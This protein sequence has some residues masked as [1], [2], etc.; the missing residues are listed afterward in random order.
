MAKL[1]MP[2]LLPA[3]R[4]AAAACR[5]SAMLSCCH[6][7]GGDS[8]GRTLQA[9]I[10]SP[11]GEEGGGIAIHRQ[12][13]GEHGTATCLFIKACNAA[14]RPGYACMCSPA[15]REQNEVLGQPYIYCAIVRP[16]MC[17]EECTE[18]AHLL[19]G[20]CCICVNGGRRPRWMSIEVPSTSESLASQAN[21]IATLEGDAYMLQLEHYGTLLS[22]SA[23]CVLLITSSQLNDH[24]V[25]ASKSLKSCW[26]PSGSHMPTLSMHMRLST[27]IH[28]KEL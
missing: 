13:E 14:G 28:L 8:R 7:L 4:A 20:C 25:C 22:C 24:K 6:G 17:Y 10:A 15:E 5:Q 21:A 16:C 1:S 26:G 18:S 27:L 23:G 12:P 2:L 3:S 11:A 9:C 19:A